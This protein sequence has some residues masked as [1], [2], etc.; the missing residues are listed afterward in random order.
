MYFDSS[1]WGAVTL[2]PCH[3]MQLLQT[4]SPPLLTTEYGTELL[5]MAED[6]LMLLTSHGIKLVDN[7][8][9]RQ[10]M[11]VQVNGTAHAW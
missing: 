2:L 7:L 6:G 8:A 10:Q 1:R 3:M 4:A 11:A 9:G 5:N